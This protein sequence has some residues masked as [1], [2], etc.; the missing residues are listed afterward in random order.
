MW[1][2]IDLFVGAL[3]QA[4]LPKDLLLLNDGHGFFTLA[5]DSS[6]PTRYGGRNWGTGSV[7]VAD[8]DGD[9]W[10]DLMNTVYSFDYSEGTVQIL[11]NNRDGTFRD[12][13]ELIL[14]PAWER[15]GN[16]LADVAVYPSDAIPADF[17]GDGYID[18]LVVSSNQPSRLFLNT[19]P[20]GGNRLVEVTELLPD[21]ADVF[22]VADFNGDGS[23]DVAVWNRSFTN[24]SYLETG[25]PA[26]T[27]S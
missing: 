6:L 10:P 21:S 14:Q 1:G 3:D 17:N 16:L 11:L 9:G 23:P 18:L 8:L 5:P 20:A 27:S 12:A 7:R 19:G 22:A 26:A 25:F 2:H 15:H 4:N 13:T 24:P